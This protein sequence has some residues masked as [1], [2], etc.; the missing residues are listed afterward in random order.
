MDESAH[1]KVTRYRLTAAIAEK[2]IKLI[3]AVSDNIRWA[4]HALQRM[5]EREIL[6]VDVLR[7]LRDGMI[8]GE[9]EETPRGGEWKCK[10]VRKLRGSR[11]AGV[12][13]IILRGSEFL[14][15]KTVEW[16]DLP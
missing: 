13:A 1:R 14:L 2:R 8:S 10:M 16:E 15:V 12:V 4:V 7:I 9:P 11:E 5:E 3:A 6:D